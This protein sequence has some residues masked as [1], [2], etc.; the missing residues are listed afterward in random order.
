[1][2]QIYRY[3][4]ERLLSYW[5]QSVHAIIEFVVDVKNKLTCKQI[6]YIHTI[7]IIS[8]IIGHICFSTQNSNIT[9]A[10]ITNLIQNLFFNISCTIKIYKITNLQNLWSDITVSSLLESLLQWRTLTALLLY[11]Y[12]M[13]TI[14]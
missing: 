4:S 14:L 2:Q 10:Q 12:A 1:M 6:L 13:G 5:Q 9:V 8:L 7:L 11:I 3:I